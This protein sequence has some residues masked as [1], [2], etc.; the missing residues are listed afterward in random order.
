MRHPGVRLLVVTGGPGVVK[1][2]M[3]SGKKVIAAGPGNPPAVVDETADLDV[4]AAGHRAR[5]VDRQ[6]HHLHRGE[7]GHRGRVDRRRRCWSG[8]GAAGCLVLNERQLQGA[9][10]GGAACRGTTRR[11]PQQGLRRQ[12]RGGDRPPDRRQ[13]GRRAAPA[14]RRR[15]REAPVRAAR[16]ADAGAAAGARRPTPT[17][18]IAMAKRVEHGFGHTAV[19]YSRNIAHL[20]AMARTINTSIFVKNASNLAGPRLRRRGLHV[21]HDR[22]ADGRGADHGPQLHAR[23]PLHAEGILPHRLTRPRVRRW[24]RRWPSIELSSI[25]RGHRVADA[26]LKR[27]PVRLLRADSV[28]PG[29]FLVL[30]DGRRRRGR[31]VVPRRRRR[32]RRSHRRQAVPAAAARRA[33]AGAGGRGERGRRRRIAGRSSRPRP[34]RRRCCAADAAAKAAA[35]AHHR[36]AARARHRRQGV[37]HRDRPARPRSR[38]PSRRRSACSTRR[39][40]TR[41]RSSR[42]RTPISSPN[43]ARQDRALP[44]FRANRHRHVGVLVRRHARAAELD[45]QRARRRRQPGQRRRGRRARARGRH[46]PLRDRARLRHQRGAAGQG[47]GAPPAQRLRAA[48]QAAAPRE[49]RRRSRRSWRNRSRCWASTRSTCCRSTG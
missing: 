49:S 11:P 38:P 35:G 15:R 34:S 30:V 1:A 18:A 9:G 39:W 21:V 12:E 24:A 6:Q 26:M 46:Q 45:A 2:A 25:A 32:G 14:G 7:G 10:E 16:D 37:L 23:A 13:R 20:H 31:R 33:L 40:C 28:S 19:M 43:C 8:W 48:D 3:G 41:P 22:V 36:D 4:A 29:K 5:R 27:A 47:A 17:E 42:R 44:A